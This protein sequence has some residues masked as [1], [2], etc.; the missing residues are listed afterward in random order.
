[1]P[2]E[3]S[4]YNKLIKEQRATRQLPILHNAR[5]TNY[6]RNFSRLY[7]FATEQE[8]EA[9]EYRRIVERLLI[10]SY[11]G[12]LK[13]NPLHIP[14][15]NRLDVPTRLPSFLTALNHL[16]YTRP[17]DYIP[18]G[19][20]SDP[21]ITPY[22]AIIT[23]RTDERGRRLHVPSKHRRYRGLNDIKAI[24]HLDDRPHKIVEPTGRARA[25]SPEDFF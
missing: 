20:A 18:D 14:S 4:F 8:I 1:M 23:P 9:R 19:Y 10:F 17:V 25:R 24:Y 6:Q 21:D 16:N 12:P 11:P 5:V 13:P 15:I 7:Q 3:E 22:P 2:K